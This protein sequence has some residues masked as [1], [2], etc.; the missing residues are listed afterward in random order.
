VVRSDG[1]SGGYRWGNERKQQL[2]EKERGESR[3][4]AERSPAVLSKV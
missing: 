2:L 4:P 1:S 3:L